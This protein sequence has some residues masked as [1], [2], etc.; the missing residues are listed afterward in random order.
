M[1]KSCPRLFLLA[2]VF[3]LS[4]LFPQET[5]ACEICK[6]NFFLGYIPCRPVTAEETGATICT[7]TY[8]PWSGY[9]CFES[10]NYCSNIT[11][12]GGGGSGGG[13]GGGWGGGGGCG[14]GGFCPSECFT[15]GG[16]GA[17]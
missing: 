7:G 15:C 9:L 13:G 1:P 14:G 8:D 10:G 12:G 3:A 2:A 17:N 5:K 16:G 4:F 11:V 6:L